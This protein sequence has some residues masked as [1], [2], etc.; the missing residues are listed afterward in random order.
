MIT[1]RMPG[2]PGQASLFDRC[3]RSEATATDSMSLTIIFSSTVYDPHRMSV[4]RKWSASLK[5]KLNTRPWLV[6]GMAV[7]MRSVAEEGRE[8]AARFTSEHIVF[9]FDSHLRN[10]I[11]DSRR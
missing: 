10:S 7:G 9:P 1:L 6:G 3:D 8:R 11:H 4:Y 2:K 5:G